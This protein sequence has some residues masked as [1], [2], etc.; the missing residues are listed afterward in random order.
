VTVDGTL[1]QFQLELN[2][3][4]ASIPTSFIQTAGATAF[5]A[6]DFIQFPTSGHIQA[7]AA[8]GAGTVMCQLTRPHP[9]IAAS[10]FASTSGTLDRFITSGTLGGSFI[11]VSHANVQITA[12]DGGSPSDPTT[13]KVI[14]AWDGSGRCI[15]WNAG[16]PVCDTNTFAPA[17]PVFPFSTN[18]GIN[19]SVPGKRLTFWSTRLSSATEQLLTK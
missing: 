11:S 5:R 13:D 16:S 18:G 14:I 2:A 15:V 19:P 9:A 10:C 17:A 3:T 12:L 1:G 8:S 6:T 7:L 4:A